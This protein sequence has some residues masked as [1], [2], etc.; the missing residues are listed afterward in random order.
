MFCEL[1]ADNKEHGSSGQ[2]ENGH[3]SPGIDSTTKSGEQYQAGS[4]RSQQNGAQIVNR[5]VTRLANGR[6]GNGNNPQGD[7][8]NGQID[9]ENPAPGEGI[10]KK[11]AK[12]R[13]GDAC[14]TIDGTKHA[15]IASALTRRHNISNNG[16]AQ[17]NQSPSAQ[18]L[19][20]AKKNEFGHVLTEAAQRRTDEE[21]NNRGME[22]PFPPVKITQLAPEWCRNSR[23]Q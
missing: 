9:V 20:S 18:S 15:L 19:Q 22:E 23:G 4:S 3:R 17:N 7:Y 2:Q 13:P 16:L 21:E 11:A 6:E 10:D 12:Q 8:A 1:C 5:V 14:Q